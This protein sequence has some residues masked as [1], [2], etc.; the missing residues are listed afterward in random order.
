MDKTIKF[1]FHSWLFTCLP[2]FVYGITLAK[3]FNAALMKPTSANITCGSPAE[4]YYNTKQGVVAPRYRVL[5]VC[6][7]SI[8]FLARPAQYLVDGNISTSWQSTNN[9]DK[10]YITINLGQVSA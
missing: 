1:L 9:V 2:S 10:A 7:S 5:S 3:G 8:P 4:Q 6:D